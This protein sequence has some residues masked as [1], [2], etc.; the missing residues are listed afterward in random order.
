MK[1]LLLSP[2]FPPQGSGAEI[3]SVLECRDLIEYGLDVVLVTNNRVSIAIDEEWFRK[4]RV[5]Q[6]PM[7]FISFIYPFSKPFGEFNYWF[8]QKFTWK[9]VYNIAIREKVD[10]IH[11]QHAYIG[12]K[13][14]KGLP[15]V[16]TIRDY[17]PIC[18]YRTLFSDEEEC[19]AF[20]SFIAGFPCRRKT[21]L[22]YGL[23]KVPHLTYNMYFAP[24][25]NMLSRKLHSMISTAFQEIDQ[26]IAI[27]QFL[28]NIICKNLNIPFEKVDVIY[29]PLPNLPYVPRENN[30][31]KITFTYIGGL[32]AHKGVKNL[33][34][35]FHIAIDR[36]KE[37][38]L[39]LCGSGA[40]KKWLKNYIRIANLEKYV[41]VL[42]KVDPVKFYDIYK[43]TDVLVVPSL[44][45]EPFGR[46][47]IEALCAGRPVVVN[48]IGGLKEQIIDGFN[49]FYVDC[50][51]IY[52]LAE[53]ILSI[54]K[55]S[56]Q[57]LL[58]MGL[59]AREDVLKRFC[60]EKR[61]RKLL[62]IY[63]SII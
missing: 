63:N 38:E 19:C 43:R 6:I 33:L 24:L 13:K 1:L 34:R 16:L 36:N 59:K 53:G 52:K 45:F 41:K 14:E 49:G 11:I 2:M 60:S 7:S 26:F 3:S 4:V 51:D 20:K 12:F 39:L 17:W 35:A 44:W 5:Y 46:V 18:S 42:G 28:K 37:V 48:P 56:K 9:Y 10:L 32:E 47:V 29:P 40:L 58:Q 22:E 31:S 62:R 57:E 61:V 25:L 55:M 8:F 15:I 54:S 23:K 21:Y 30:S 27:S 50:Y